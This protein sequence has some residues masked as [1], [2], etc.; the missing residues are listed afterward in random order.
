MGKRFKNPE[1]LR[2]NVSTE[3][4]KIKE[5]QQELFDCLDRLKAA[6]GAP[7]EKINET[8]NQLDKVLRKSLG[9]GSDP[10][11]VNTQ[12]LTTA[13]TLISDMP[14]GERKFLLFMILENGTI[15]EQSTGLT[16][17]VND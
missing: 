6:T 17:R 4:Q 2:Y 12:D 7:A 9:V 15:V 14:K 10:I 11:K 5:A 13:M 1:D 3:V 8:K 16:I